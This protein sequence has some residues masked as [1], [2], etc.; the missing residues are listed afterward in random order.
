M[1]RD[2]W[3]NRN[4]LFYL[5]KAN[6][7]E[8][9]VG[10]NARKYDPSGYVIE[11][12]NCGKNPVIIDSVSLHWKNSRIDSIECETITILPYHSHEMILA[13]Q[14][15]MEIRRWGEVDK[16]LKE[17]SVIAHTVSGNRIKGK[18]N[19]ELIKMQFGL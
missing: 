7:D 14:D 6:I 10:T 19:L 5:L 4:R 11:V 15:Y 17:V 1:A 3:Y 12:Y 9:F 18:L 16:N 13:V 2:W 8:D